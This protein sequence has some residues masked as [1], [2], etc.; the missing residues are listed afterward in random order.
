M[1]KKELI[2]NISGILTDQEK[3]LSNAAIERVLDATAQTI[4][5]A[6]STD[7][8]VT[9]SGIGKFKVAERAERHARNPQTGEQMTIPAHKVVLF[10]VAKSLKESLN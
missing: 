7:D 2:M 10:R 6:L 4:Q 5:E 3:P 1:T 9:L 8:E